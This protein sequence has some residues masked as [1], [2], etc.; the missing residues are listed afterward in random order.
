MFILFLFSCS[1]T[2]DLSNVDTS[3]KFK[4]GVKIYV[5]PPF[6]EK[7]KMYSKLKNDLDIAGVL[8]SSPF[9]KLEY[10]SA[11][12]YFDERE[13]II[14]FPVDT[15]KWAESLSQGAEYSRLEELSGNFKCIYTDE[16]HLHGDSVFGTLFSAFV[17][18]NKT[19]VLYRYSKSV[20]P[21]TPFI[22]GE[23]SSPLSNWWE[24]YISYCDGML[25][26][27]FN[28]RQLATMKA[29]TNIFHDN[30]IGWIHSSKNLE[31]L[32]ELF[33]KN[34]DEIWIY[35][36][37]DTENFWEELYYIVDKLKDQGKYEEVK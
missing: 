19:K 8:I 24:P 21:N 12:K 35:S 6:L 36:A 25:N 10:D 28:S 1:S 26:T 30:R 13:L 34:F 18:P 33:W 27:G 11:L 7:G 4:A 22:V 3:R 17:F 32:D 2:V 37:D 15:S 5:W 31:N 23:Y 14:A 9:Y 20:F 29:M 16:P